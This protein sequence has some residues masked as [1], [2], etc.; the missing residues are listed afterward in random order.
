MS[1]LCVWRTF[2]PLMGMA[3]LA[4]A[5]NL[6][7]MIDGVVCFSCRVVCVIALCVGIDWESRKGRWQIYLISEFF[8]DPRWN[9]KNMSYCLA[10]TVSYLSRGH[11]P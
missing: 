6:A 3:T 9:Y 7:R 1:D 5:W 11:Q 10:S 2:R 8:R 4:M